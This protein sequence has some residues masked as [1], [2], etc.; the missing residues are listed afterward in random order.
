MELRSSKSQLE[1]VGVDPG[2]GRDCHRRVAKQKAQHAAAGDLVATQ[3]HVRDEDWAVPLQVPDHDV[4][5]LI[6][7]SDGELVRLLHG[8]EGRDVHPL[9]EGPRHVPPGRGPLRVKDVLSPFSPRSIDDLGDH[10]V[11]PVLLFLEE[12]ERD[13]VESDAEIARIGQQP[14]GPTRPPPQPS[15]HEVTGA[16]RQGPCATRKVIGLAEVRRRR[17][18][19]G[20]ERDRVEEAGELVEIEQRHEDAVAEGVWD[21]AQAAMRHPPLV[22]RGARH[23]A[24]ASAS[25]AGSIGC[26]IGASPSA[27]GN[28]PRPPSRSDTRSADQTP[29]S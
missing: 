29:S 7:P 18:T 14:H 11:E 19:R 20:P 2:Q 5:S 12:E 9:P 21:G 16:L 10:T 8:L 13:R 22:D 28:G 17:A 23:A 15:L 25:A 4:E 1:G 6:R 26:S 24:S 3:G 27:R